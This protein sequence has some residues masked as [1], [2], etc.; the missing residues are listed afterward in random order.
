MKSLVL[1]GACILIVTIFKKR[2][3][4]TFISQPRKSAA[5]WL[6]Q[7]GCYNEQFN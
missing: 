4:R 3:Y 2:V 6:L 1:A 5:G 7:D